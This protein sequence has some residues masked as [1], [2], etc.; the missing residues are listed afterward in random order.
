M[1][2]Q[3]D[4][5]PEQRAVVGVDC[6]GH[7]LGQQAVDGVAA[8]AGGE[9]EDLVG[10][11]ADLDADIAL[12]HHPHDARVARQG[13]AVADA[14]RAQDQRV[15]EVAVRVGADVER[16]AAVEQEGYLHALL[17]AFR[18]E[19]DELV[20]EVPQGPALAL[21]SDQIEAC[22]AAVRSPA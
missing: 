9:A 11:G 8:D 13:K 12:L 14:L 19:P 22:G 2:A 7:I 16:L 3:E 6:A 21:F 18:L 4:D 17:R 20:S 10:D 15:D 1:G 5:I